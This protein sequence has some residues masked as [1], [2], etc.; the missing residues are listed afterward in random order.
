MYFG[1]TFIGLSLGLVIG[2][3]YSFVN[4]SDWI[5]QYRYHLEGAAL[6]GMI[7]SYSLFKYFFSSE[8]INIFEIF[9][10]L[11]VGLI[12]GM[13]WINSAKYKTLKDW[14]GDFIKQTTNNI[15]F[16][17]AGSM[18]D[19]EHSNV[20]GKLMLTQN[21]VIFSPS[22]ADNKEIRTDLSAINP[23]LER[24]G[25]DTFNMPSGV[26]LTQERS[27][28]PNKFPR[29]WLEEIRNIRSRVTHSGESHD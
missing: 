2:L 13:L 1:G 4:P 7:G 24:S 27:I 11:I 21:E 16:S 25:F 3:Y 17:D 10:P 8:P 18:A 9:I 12:F 20:K 23:R 28:Y 22:D 5:F 6:A 14:K 26:Q 29:Y 19:S 15:L